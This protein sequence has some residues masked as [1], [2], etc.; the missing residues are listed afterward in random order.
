MKENIVKG[1]NPELIVDWNGNAIQA[2]TLGGKTITVVSGDDFKCESTLMRICNTGTTLTRLKLKDAAYS[3]LQPS[4]T[5]D[6]GTPV[7]PNSCV[8]VGVYE[9]GQVYS[10]EGGSVDIT[11]IMDRRVRQTTGLPPSPSF[12][13][14]TFSQDS[15]KVAGPGAIVN[16]ITAQNIL[17]YKGIIS[18]NS[19][20]GGHIVGIKITPTVQITDFPDAVIRIIDQYGERDYGVEVFD[21]ANDLTWYFKVEEIPC[22]K[23]TIQIFWGTKAGEVFYVQIDPTTLLGN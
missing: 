7:L 20:R 11:F 23:F 4:T 15:E 12:T 18:Y 14:S 5:G 8:M 13:T 2:W 3:E 21:S 9:L 17:E 16:K 22:I 1:N 6:V 10:I 19:H